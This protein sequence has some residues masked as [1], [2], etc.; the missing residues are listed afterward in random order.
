M[1]WPQVKIR[2]IYLIN[3]LRTPC[4][5]LIATHS[6]NQVIMIKG[7]EE[8]VDAVEMLIF[9]FFSEI[10]LWAVIEVKMPDSITLSYPVWLAYGVGH[11]LNDLCSSIWFSYTLLFF[12]FVLQFDS[13]L[14]GAAIVI[15]QI[16]DGLSTPI[17]GILSDKRFDHWVCKYGR[18]KIWHLLG[19][20]YVNSLN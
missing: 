3:L 15:G 11:V 19:T 18:R 9:F 12:E 16:A 8:S 7:R 20:Y 17:V 4:S 1:W 6:S 5:V 13:S 14:A 2:H 10:N